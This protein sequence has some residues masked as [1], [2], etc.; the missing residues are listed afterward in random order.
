M[1]QSDDEIVTGLIGVGLVIAAGYG[2]Y[3][4]MKKLGSL[5]PGQMVSI[6]QVIT[7]VSKKNEVQE[8]SQP[9]RQSYTS[10]LVLMDCPKCGQGNSFVPWPGSIACCSSCGDPLE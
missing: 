7:E 5:I 1:S 3:R 8:R 9:Y 10:G 2:A 6:D 4:L